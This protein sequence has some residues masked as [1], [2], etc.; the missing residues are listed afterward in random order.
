MPAT[1]G[2]GTDSDGRP[3]RGGR[4]TGAAGDERE[5]R[6]MVDLAIMGAGARGRTFAGFAERHPPLARVVAVADPRLDR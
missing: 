2:R 1:I 6:R 4:C 5:A 3:G